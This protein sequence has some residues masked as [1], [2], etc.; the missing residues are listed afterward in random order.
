M[1]LPIYIH[2][3]LKYFMN[4]ILL[5]SFYNSLISFY[6]S[7]LYSLYIQHYLEINY[8]FQFH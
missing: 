4:H 6:S 5:F 1:I 7:M 2:I 3:H 8:E